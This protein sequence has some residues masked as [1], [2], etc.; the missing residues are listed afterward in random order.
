MTFTIRPIKNV[1]INGKDFVVARMQFNGEIPNRPNFANEHAYG[2]MEIDS[3]DDFNNTLGDWLS[4]SSIDKAI[5]NRVDC[6]NMREIGEKYDFDL[7][8]QDFV[9]EIADYIKSRN[10]PT[11][12][13]T[14][15]VNGAIGR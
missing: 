14:L 6:E 2:T 5:E 4:S 15:I 1:K 8:N 7:N 11:M 13:A 10:I 3:V 9:K 12:L